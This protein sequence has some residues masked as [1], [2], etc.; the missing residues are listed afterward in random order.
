MKAMILAAGRGERMKPLTDRTAKPLLPVGGKPLIEYHLEHLAAI[1]IEQIVINLAWKGALIRDALG[2]GGRFGVRITYS[3]EGD[4]ALETGGG[5]FKALP[6]LGPGPFVVISGDVWTDYPLERL[7]HVLQEGDVAHFVVVPNPDFH[8][9]GDFGL[10]QS[11]LVRDGE[12]FTY[13]NL[14]VFRPEFFA[15]CAPGR[16]ALA[17]LMFEWID[18]RKVSGEL[19]QGRW[20]NVGT[21]AQRA[22]LDASLRP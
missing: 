20:H 6:L 13:G 12:K 17:P 16:F 2:D 4:A 10:A 18:R 1:G 21:P 19:Y 8:T 14:G 22:Q 3:D 15:G 9:Q 7:T 11:R 5:V